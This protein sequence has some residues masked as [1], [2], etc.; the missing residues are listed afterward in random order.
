MHTCVDRLST[1][2]YPNIREQEKQKTPFFPNMS[3]VIV[4]TGANRGI[5]LALAKAFS[6]Q[7]H[8]VIATARKPEDAKQ[9]RALPNV[10][11]IVKAE[12]ADLPSLPRVAEE[13]AELAP[14]GI[15]ELWN[16][17]PTNFSF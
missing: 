1:F 17:R 8:K 7:G 16:V 6:D 14:D 3:K 5:G 2:I 9:L 12:M 4:I 11:G 10:I 13:I 15:D